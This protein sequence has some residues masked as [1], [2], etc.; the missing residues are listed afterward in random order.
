MFWAVGRL[1]D[2]LRSPGG[3]RAP[4]RRHSCLV[5]GRC[6][7]SSRTTWA[8]RGA[9]R[10]ALRLRGGELAF[11]LSLAL[12]VV[13]NLERLFFLVIIVPVIGAFFLV[14][15]L[16]SRWAYRATDHPAVAALANAVAFAWALGVTFPLLAG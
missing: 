9:G 6:P 13:L 8:T 4:D 15:G 10:G 7:T 2:E 14:Y 16:I 11:V 1:R 3:A 5:G 12:A